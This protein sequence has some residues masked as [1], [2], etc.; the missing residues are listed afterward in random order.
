MYML[1]TAILVECYSVPLYT[2][3]I[4]FYEFDIARIRIITLIEALL[5]C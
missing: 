2:H 4:D 5:C 3:E 1:R